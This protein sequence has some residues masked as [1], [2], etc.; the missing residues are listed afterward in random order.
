MLLLRPVHG[1]DTAV[2]EKPE[3]RLF[4][5]LHMLSSFRCRTSKKIVEYAE[6]PLARGGTR[7]AI[8][9]EIEIERLDA[10]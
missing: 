2:T 8:V 7:Y 9:L 1:W 4:E 3:R 5:K 6:V 10:A